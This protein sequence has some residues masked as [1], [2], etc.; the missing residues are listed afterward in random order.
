MIRRFSD[1]LSDKAGAIQKRVDAS[2][3]WSTGEY[4]VALTHE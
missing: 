3:L 4:K 2:G 1:Y